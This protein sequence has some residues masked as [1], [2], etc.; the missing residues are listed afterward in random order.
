MPDDKDNREQICHNK[1]C[2]DVTIARCKAESG[3]QNELMFCQKDGYFFVK[4]NGRER[5]RTDSRR[6]AYGFY[7]RLSSR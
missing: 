7:L 4:A 1:G 3:G 6:A 5:L 2:D